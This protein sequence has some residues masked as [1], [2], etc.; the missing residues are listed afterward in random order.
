M[1]KREIFVQENCAKKL[2]QLLKRQGLQFS[3]FGVFCLCLLNSYKFFILFILIPTIS[4]ADQ[5]LSAISGSSV[6]EEYEI[7]G[8]QSHGLGDAGIVAGPSLDSVRLNP[9]MLA[10]EKD[11]KIAGGYIWPVVGRNFYHFGI[12]DS[13]SSEISAGVQ[14]TGFTE[15]FGETKSWDGLDSPILKRLAFAG[16]GQFGKI[17]L[18]AGGQ[19]IE[20]VVLDEDGVSNRVIQGWTLGTGFV[21]PLGDTFRIGASAENLGSRNLGNFA[22]TIYRAGASFLLVGGN[23]NINLDLRQRSVVSAL[24]ASEALLTAD[25]SADSLKMSDQESER[26]AI[27]SGSSVIYDL[28]RLSVGYGR[29]IGGDSREQVSAGFSFVNEKAT[30]SYSMMKPQRNSP[31]WSQAVSAAFVAQM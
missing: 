12:M 17:A 5:P 1:I 16:A 29:N 18:G 27:I 31:T 19:Y 7:T 21:L 30:F 11:Y 26:M 13:K 10:A 8:A 23:A 20:G 6:P 9:G 15:R 22:P 14:Y 28:L 25:S 4:F 2:F 3:F 24:G